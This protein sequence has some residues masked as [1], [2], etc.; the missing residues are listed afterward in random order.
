MTFLAMIRARQ[1]TL[2]FLKANVPGQITALNI[3]GVSDVALPLDFTTYS[4]APLLAQPETP[5]CFVIPSSTGF[6]GTQWDAQIDSQHEFDI[7]IE[8][9]NQDEE[10]AMQQMLGM[11]MAVINTVGLWVKRAA[12]M[13]HGQ[14][15]L[16]GS[17][18]SAE[19]TVTFQSV[20]SS[21][22]TPFYA[23]CVIPCTVFQSETP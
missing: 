4:A 2:A 6:R 12:S 8:V 1:D 10:Q 23:Q 7:C 3:I 17:E 13:A 15:I 22:E 11:T 5:A 9:G 16:Y 18:S 21:T 20:A 14:Q 19:R